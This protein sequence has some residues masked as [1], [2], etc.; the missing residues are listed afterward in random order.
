[1]FFITS[2]K[3]V[4]FGQQSWIAYNFEY[5]YWPILK[6]FRKPADKYGQLSPCGHLA[7]TDTS[8]LRTGAEILA[9]KNLLNITP[10]LMDWL[11]YGHQILV[12]MVSV[13]TTVD[14]NNK[15]IHAGELVWIQAL[16]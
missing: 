14:W 4:H 3:D 8:L 7:S 6:L 5:V 12:P 16:Q 1:M 11:Y 15:A 10:A 13:M 9:K 2:A